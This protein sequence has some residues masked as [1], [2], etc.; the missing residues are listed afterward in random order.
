MSSP[1]QTELTGQ[2]RNKLLPTGINIV[3]YARTKMDRAEYLSRVKSYMKTPTDDMKKQLDQFCELCTYI[4][5]QYDQD[6]S[7]VVLKN[8]LEELEKGQPETNR[9]FYMALPPT[10]FIPVSQHLKKICY[11]T[12]GIARV[13]V[14]PRP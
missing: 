11:P 1:D 9:I 7:F 6:E 13:I 5:G 8:H 12:K 10:V 2:Y 14:R 3:G 4:S